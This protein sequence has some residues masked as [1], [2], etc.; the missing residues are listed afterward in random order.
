MGPEDVTS[1]PMRFHLLG[2]KVGRHAKRSMYVLRLANELESTR[3]GI[4]A[5]NYIGHISFRM[6]VNNH[7][8]RCVAAS[9][10]DKP[11]V[12]GEVVELWR[13]LEP[14]GRFLVRCDDNVGEMILW[15]DVG[16][17]KARRKTSQCL[18]EKER[19]GKEKKSQKR[20]RSEMPDGLV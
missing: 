6:L 14:M 18:R 10:V 8:P 1:P 3:G 2:E 19:P 16:D 15:K 7:K 12:V 20:K 4:V 11:K 17:I 13:K 5:S 9:R